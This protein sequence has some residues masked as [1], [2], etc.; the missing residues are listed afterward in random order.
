MTLQERDVGD[1]RIYAGALDAPQGGYTAAVEVHL[2]SRHARGPVVVFSSERL[3]CGHRF[4]Q[5]DA[6]I[7]HAIQVGNQ[8]IRLREA[9]L[10]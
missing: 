2:L 6:A 1:F 7:K 10:N 3:S 4:P 8:A 9:E 5:A